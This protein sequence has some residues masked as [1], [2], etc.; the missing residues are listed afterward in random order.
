MTA[1]IVLKINQAN[2]ENDFETALRLCGDAL[3]NDPQNA[4]FLI[5]KGN[6]LFGLKRA[7]E[8]VSAYLAAAQADETD[9]LPWANLAGVYYDMRRL[10]DGLA[11]CAEALKRDGANVN[12]LIHRGNLF[13]LKEDFAAALAA[14]NAAEKITPEDTLVL[15]NKANA[16]SELDRPDEAEEIYAELA[17]K[18]PADE[19]VLY[20]LAS[21][22]EKAEK[23]APAARAY[24]RLLQIRETP[25]LHITLGGCLYNML[26]KEQD[27][28]PILDDWLNAFPTNPVALHTLK[29]ADRLNPAK[30]A[31]A[32]Y[33]SELFD[34]FA[35]S[36]DSVLQGLDYQA[37]S[38]IA[39]T[40]AEIAPNSPA[41][42]DL[43]CGTGLCGVE[44][45]KRLKPACLTG[46]DLSDGMLEKARARKI[47]D[48][49]RQADITVFSRE[50]A[51]DLVVSADVLTYLGDLSAVFEN[52]RKSLKTGG[53][54]VLTVSENTEHPDKYEME[55]SG[56]FTHGEDYIRKT[57][58][59]FE[60]R[61]LSR[62]EL[63]KELN[64]PVM[65][66]LVAARKI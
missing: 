57:L 56:R 46:V 36:F 23:F 54:F 63:R 9:S 2:S 31:A 53:Y 8:A 14:Y 48:E 25:V 11:A 13:M 38:L 22:L 32:D 61:T 49:L 27:I 60:I 47:Y 34:A 51:F 50:N 39:Q 59:G 18:N 30:R 15:F 65:G 4:S 58:A 16:L 17:R 62:V 20:A 35:D 42:L 7:E 41:V 19:D 3:E 1:D 24:L 40:T 43:G 64:E 55:L 21:V 52:V 6:A 29:T 45:C 44:L 33:V 10:D 5:G 66:L 37:P 26:L 12:A 28:F